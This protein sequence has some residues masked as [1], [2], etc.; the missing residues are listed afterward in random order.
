MDAKGNPVRTTKGLTIIKRSSNDAGQLFFEVHCDSE[1]QPVTTTCGYLARERVYDGSGFVWMYRYY[2]KQMFCPELSQLHCEYDDLDLLT[3]AICLDE[4]G[5]KMQCAEGF[6]IEFDA[7]GAHTGVRFYALNGDE[8]ALS[9]EQR[10][11]WLWR[12]S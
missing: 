10:E 11:T 5:E 8:V 6:S 4:N 3:E 7:F 2:D 12:I 9:E 1:G